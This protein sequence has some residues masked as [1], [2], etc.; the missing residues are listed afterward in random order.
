MRLVNTFLVGPDT[1][2]I[3]EFRQRS[4]EDAFAARGPVRTGEVSI[5]R[6]P[7]CSDHVPKPN[8]SRIISP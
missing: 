8:G 1:T 4:L 6:Q 2:R 7:A 5:T 3:F